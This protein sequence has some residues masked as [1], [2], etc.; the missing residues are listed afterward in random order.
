MI[1]FLNAHYHITTTTADT[2]ISL[3][4]WS[5]K[6]TSPQEALERTTREIPQVCG[7]NTIQTNSPDGQQPMHYHYGLRKQKQS[8]SHGHHTFAI[9]KR[10]NF[11]ITLAIS[12]LKEINSS[13]RYLKNTIKHVIQNILSLKISVQNSRNYESSNILKYWQSISCQ[14]LVLLL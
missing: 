3:N 14:S 6:H 10:K 13:N 7:E 9:Q 5:R 8:A 12:K 2:E 11:T 4:V 1:V